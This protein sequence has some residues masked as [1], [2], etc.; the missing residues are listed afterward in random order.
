MLVLS[1]KEAQSITI[2]ADIT[3]TIVRIQ[4]DRVRIGIAAPPEVTIVRDDAK[5]LTSRTAG[6][7][8]A[9]E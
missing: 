2:G 9:G 5:L 6:E 8:P 3:I 4:G 1:R 7:A